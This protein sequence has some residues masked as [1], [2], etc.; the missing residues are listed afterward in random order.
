MRSSFCLL[1]CLLHPI[2]SALFLKHSL[3]AHVNV[4]NAYI[5]AICL[6]QL[7]FPISATI[8][9][10]E[11]RFVI[12]RN[13]LNLLYWSTQEESAPISAIFRAL[14][15]SKYGECTT[16]RLGETNNMKRLR[17]PLRT[18]PKLTSESGHLCAPRSRSPVG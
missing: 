17:S 14:W 15:K 5:A 11:L 9:S 4:P 7:Q 2:S 16:P 8:F 13:G 6:P 10:Y 1:F 12:L 18:Q 3:L